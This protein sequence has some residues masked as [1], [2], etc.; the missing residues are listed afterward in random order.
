MGTRA[1]F[2][3]GNGEGMEWLGSIA[4][5]GYPDG[6]EDTSIFECKTEEQYRRYV[7]AFLADREDATN[8]EDGWPWPWETSH[9]TDYSYSFFDGKVWGTNW[10]YEWFDPLKPEP[11]GDDNKEKTVVFPKMNK[12]TAAKAGSK[13]SGIMIFSVKS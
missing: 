10:G 1:D 3:V 8:P 4:W 13:R 12:E 7:K 9:T 2:Y 11:E 5:D 6:I